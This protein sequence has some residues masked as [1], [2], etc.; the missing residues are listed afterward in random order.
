MDNKD[1]E[2]FWSYVD[3]EPGG[4]WRWTRS[5]MS[6]GYG[7]FTAKRKNYAVH[8][9]SYMLAHGDIPHGL[10]VC[11]HCDNKACVRPDHLFLGTCKDNI[12]DAVRK[13]R[14]FKAIGDLSGMR[15]HPERHPTRL[16]PDRMCGENAHRAKLTWDQVNQIRSTWEARKPKLTD[17][18]K[19]YNVSPTTIGKIVH[20]ETWLAIYGKDAGNAQA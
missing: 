17:L 19:E 10:L 6:T 16:Y 7:Q 18:A 15:T 14:T 20:N 5:I 11:H 3:Q 4:C 13:G 9:L 1:I 12:R 8:R 2:R